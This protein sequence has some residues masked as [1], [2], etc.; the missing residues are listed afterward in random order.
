MSNN[1]QA[2]IKSGG[3]GRQV[4]CV[5]Y[6]FRSG[7]KIA[8]DFNNFRLVRAW[9]KA[10]VKKLFFHFRASAYIKCYL[11]TKGR[12]TFFFTLR[13]Y[14]YSLLQRI[15]VASMTSRKILWLLQQLSW[16]TLISEIGTIQVKDTFYKIK[17]LDFLIAPWTS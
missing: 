3:F 16:L 10:P 8:T 12:F 4:Q 2:A 7:S 5:C 15:L 9:K 1:S 6:S 14:F 17:T 13:K 11:Y